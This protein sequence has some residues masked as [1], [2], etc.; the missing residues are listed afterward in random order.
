[1]LLSTLQ[2]LLM[3]LSCLLWAGGRLFDEW[4]FTHDGNTSS[5]LNTLPIDQDTRNYR[6]TVLN[7]VFSV[8]TPTPFQ[9]KP[10]LA[11]LAEDA[12]RD[13]LDLIPEECRVNERFVSFVA[14]CWLHPS[15][16]HLTH[17]YGG[18]QFGYWADQLGDGRAVLLGEYVNAKGERWELQL[19][20]AGRTPYSRHGDGRAVVRSSIRE[21]LASEAMYHL[22]V[23]TSRA[24]SLVVSEDLVWRDMFYDGHPRQERTAVVL[25]LAPSW[26]RIG[27]LEILSRNGE[28][29]LLKKVVDFTIVN[30]FPNLF[31]GRNVYLEFFNTVVNQTAHL[32][33]M[34]QSLGFTHGVCNTDNFSLLSITIDYGPFG[35][36]EAY[37]SN[38]VPNSSD[39]E[40]RYKFSNQPSVGLYNLE[41]LLESLSVLL[42]PEQHLHA[43]TSLNSSY[44]NVYSGRYFALM[45]S[46]L[47][48]A[49]ADR[50]L[51]NSLLELMEDAGAD[52]TMTFRELSEI[53]TEQWQRGPLPEWFWALPYLMRMPGWH[54]WATALRNRHLYGCKIHSYCEGQRMERM[55]LTN[56]RY[57]LRNYMAEGA[58]RLAE[59]G[60]FSE[61]HALHYALGKP[62]KLQHAA[63]HKG[64]ASRP[65]QWSRQL[66]VSC[67]S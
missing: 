44:F 10:V 19:K 39:D 60:D 53:T 64:Y 55:Q 54:H 33:A 66:R 30:F 31:L 43:R 50:G 51:V 17:R 47:G 21:F 40:G 23:P 26:F 38:Y 1:M 16:L 48:L 25:R 57:V 34:W 5:H 3:M 32:M 35:F 9:S 49:E 12:L 36:M 67:S 65:P 2:T 15:A 24:A 7:A 27:S 11:L 8:T 6:R 45:S 4:D 61:L 52:Y 18:H 58:I 20:G 42:S 28:V 37:D 14:G 59:A 41:K 22:G 46:K 62:F 29:D 63:E 13:L 56:P